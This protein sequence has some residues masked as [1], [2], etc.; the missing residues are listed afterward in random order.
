MMQEI[1]GQESYRKFGRSTFPRTQMLSFCLL[2]HLRVLDSFPFLVISW[3]QGPK[4]YVWTMSYPEEKKAF[5]HAYS[6]IS[7]KTKQ[8]KKETPSRSPQHTSLL[9]P[10]ARKRSHIDAYISHMLTLHYQAMKKI[11]SLHIHMTGQ[12]DPYNGSLPARNK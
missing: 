9:V 2:C 6:F 7:K 1:W 12:R 5:L 8:N 10:L 3:L 4:N 11:I